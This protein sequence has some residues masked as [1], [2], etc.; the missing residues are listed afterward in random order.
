MG[1]CAAVRRHH[2]S[3]DAVNLAALPRLD[4]NFVVVRRHHLSGDA[5]IRQI[6]CGYFAAAL[7]LG[8]QR[9]L[10]RIFTELG[11]DLHF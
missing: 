6:I 2:L 10:P 5:V 9:F 8:G 7:R 11:T 1:S 3:G 4:G